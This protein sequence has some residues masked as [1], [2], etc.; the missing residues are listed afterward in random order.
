MIKDKVYELLKTLKYP[1]KWQVRPKLD[2]ANTTVISFHFFN[3]T[4][5]LYGNGEGLKQGGALQI[6]VFSLVDYTKTVDKIKKL[7][8]D[9]KFR[10]AEMYDDIEEIGNNQ[11]FH[12]VIIFNYEESEVL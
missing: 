9:N 4:N 10:F 2:K 8:V 6:D 3:Q 5:S 12:K 7:F 1:V 11:A